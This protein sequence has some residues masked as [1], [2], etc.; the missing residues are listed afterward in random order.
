M[1]ENKGIGT[2]DIFML[3]AVIVWGV[4]FTVIKLSLRELTP[5]GFNGIRL[6][7]A[8]LALVLVL[9]MRKESFL[10]R[11][12][13][14]RKAIVLGLIG[15]TSYQLLFIHGLNQTTV[16]NTSIIMALTPVFVAILST[17]L[18][19]EKIH[20]AGWLGIFIS[21]LGFYFIIARP[22]EAFRLTSP[23]LRG[24]LMIFAGNLFWAVYT[25]FSRPQLQRISPLKWT[26]I[27]LAV[28]TVFYLP[29]CLKDILRIPWKEVSFQSWAGLLFSAIFAISISYVVWYASV[30]RVGNSKTAVYGYLT[31]IFA[32]LIA[33]LFLA[34][35]ITLLKAAGAL[36]IFGGVYLTRLGYRHFE[37]LKTLTQRG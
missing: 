2:T 6:F 31:P 8:S 33:Y 25:V 29:F 15:H 1:E 19:H 22:A 21:F 36:I 9:L 11:R 28:G 18:K 23:D 17:V 5:Q 12:A 26:S 3:L 7:I 24:D 27:T 13:D 14:W 20:W 35:R 34:E 32:V 37:R 16:S 10:M 30:K 4:N